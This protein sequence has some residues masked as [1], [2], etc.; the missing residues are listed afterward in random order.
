MWRR[1][2]ARRGWT[3]DPDSYDDPL[4]DTGVASELQVAPTTARR[5]MRDG[6]LMCVVKDGGG[7]GRRWARLS[8]V[9]SLRDRLGDRVL[10][11]DLAEEL[12][13]RYQELYRTA[14]RLGVELERHPTRRQFELP[15][16]AAKLLRDEHAR[17]DI[18]SE[19][20]S[21]DA[22]F[23]TRVSVEKCRTARFGDLPNIK[24]KQPTV[25]LAGVVR[26]T[27]AAGSTYSTSCAPAVRPLPPVAGTR[28]KCRYALC[29]SPIR[30]DSRAYVLIGTGRGGVPAGVSD[31]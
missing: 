24:L 31:G 15:V 28:G 27:G 18:D 4:Y 12:G 2:W 26:L 6:T 30:L 8:E 14:R 1:R 5:W 3:V 13:V 29:R 10:L 20:D 22:R 19:T 16:G 21:S 17:V 9:W 11:P 25:P 23:V 7:I